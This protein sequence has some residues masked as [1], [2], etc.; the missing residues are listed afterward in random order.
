FDS[1]IFGTGT[2]P[3]LQVNVQVLGNGTLLNQTVTP[4]EAGTFDPNAVVFQHYHFSFIANSA[5]TTLR[6][7]DIGTAN[8][9]ADTLLDS[10]AVVQNLLANP[11]FETAPFASP[12]NVTSWVVGGNA[13]VASLAD[14]AT[15][16]MHSAA[17]SAGPD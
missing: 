6:F 7:T 4:P 8:A 12:G 3:D 10:V 13:S 16:P 14:G 1:G 15:S 5:I 2:G 11:D 17:I 9:N